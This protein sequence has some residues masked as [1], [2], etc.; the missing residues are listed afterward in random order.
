MAQR[1]LIPAA[2]HRLV[3]DLDRPRMCYTFITGIFAIE[4]GAIGDTYE[5]WKM[6]SNR[7]RGHVAV[8]SEG[9]RIDFTA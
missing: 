2:E 5:V 9:E 1:T 3:P 6:W 4:A 8:D 7:P